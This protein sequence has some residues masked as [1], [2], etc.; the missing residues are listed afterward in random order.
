[1]D[2]GVLWLVITGFDGDVEAALTQLGELAVSR[3]GSLPPPQPV[4]PAPS[5]QADATLESLF[6]G[7]VGGEPL[8]PTSAAGQALS[9][10]LDPDMVETITG[11]LE[12]QGKTIDDLSVALAFPSTGGA[13]LGVRVT[14]G[15]AADVAPAVLTAMF[16]ATA[17]GG[18][19]GKVAG[20]DVSILTLGSTTAYLYEAGETAW[21][22]QADEPALTEILEALP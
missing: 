10:Q 17:S 15:D 6:P 22:V 1:M 3:A 13:I 8:T 11:I 9:A 2:A 18:T 21:Y 7:A 5:L 16:G 19:S 12:A 14:G 20:K 4:E